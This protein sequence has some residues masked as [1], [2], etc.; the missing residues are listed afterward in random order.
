MWIINTNIYKCIEN[1][2]A[3][4]IIKLKNNKGEI[5]KDIPDNKRCHCGEKQWG[6]VAI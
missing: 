2:H 3:F 5:V 6:D 1:S 4:K